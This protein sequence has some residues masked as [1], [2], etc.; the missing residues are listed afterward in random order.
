MQQTK[1]FYLTKRRS[2]DLLLVP[3]ELIDLYQ[4]A[5]GAV[6]VALWL[7]LFACQQQE[8]DFEQLALELKCT[9]ATL[10]EALSCL[11]RYRLVSQERGIDRITLSVNEPLPQDNLRPYK[12]QFAGADID[13]LR[14]F[15]F[16]KNKW[17]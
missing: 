2:R 1:S 17:V 10:E 8:I 12:G 7:N 4:P 15:D 6:G 13:A 16:I 5:I 3:K 14:Y 11:I 9:K